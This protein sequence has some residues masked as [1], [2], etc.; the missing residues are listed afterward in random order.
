[1]NGMKELM[2][3]IRANLASIRQATSQVNSSIQSMMDKI[4]GTARA[5]MDKVNNAFKS[6]INSMKSELS[7]VANATGL[8]SVFDSLRNKVRSTFTDIRTY[9]GSMRNTSNMTE[10][11]WGR[12]FNDNG[13]ARNLFGVI[14]KVGQ[15]AQSVMGNPRMWGSY[16]INSVSQ[17]LSGLVDRFRRVGQSVG[18]AMSNP[19]TWGSHVINSVGQSLSGLVDRFRRV[20]Q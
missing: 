4:G 9:I 6:G 2:I 5:G 8:M 18:Q 10:D 3:S 15:V 17:S 14:Y 13:Q 20:G 1:M 19:R 11:L 12:L 16:A 7:G